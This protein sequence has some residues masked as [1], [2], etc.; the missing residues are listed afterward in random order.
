MDP[1]IGKTCSNLFQGERDQENGREREKGVQA[2]RERGRERNRETEA[3][4]DREDTE[5]QR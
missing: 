2:E 5:R 1:I 4:R 3:Q